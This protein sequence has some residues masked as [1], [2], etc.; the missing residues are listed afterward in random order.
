[1]LLLAQHRCKDS[2]RSKLVMALLRA[3]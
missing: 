2:R 1:M 3:N